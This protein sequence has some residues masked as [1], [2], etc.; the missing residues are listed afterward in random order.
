MKK[1]ISK[2]ST[3]LCAL[4]L[5]TGCATTNNDGLFKGIVDNTI[6]N[7]QDRQKAQERSGQVPD[8]QIKGLDVVVG[9]VNAVLDKVFGDGSEDD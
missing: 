1:I 4:T 2:V 5:F 7:Q 9:T 8:N 6:S 3:L